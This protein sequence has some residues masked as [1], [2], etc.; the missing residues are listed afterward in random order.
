MDADWF[1]WGRCGDRL[2]LVKEPTGQGPG[3]LV[4]M[5]VNGETVSTDTGGWSGFRVR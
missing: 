3:I 2:K 5:T 4:N 1:T